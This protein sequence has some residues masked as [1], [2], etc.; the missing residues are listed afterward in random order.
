MKLSQLPF[1]PVFFD[2]YLQILPQELELSLGFQTLSAKQIFSLSDL[3]ALGEKVYAPGKW[4]AKETVQHC[5]DTERIL[6]YR[7]L[8]IARGEKQSLPGFDEN[9]YAQQASTAQR[10]LEELM[11]EFYCV[12][13][14]TSYLFSSFSEEILLRSGSANGTEITVAALGFAILGHGMHHKIIL[15]ERYL[16]LV[17]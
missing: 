11:A 17:R 1:V 3:Q 6:A 4:T 15:D 13:Q 9:A 14:S 5:I 10:S 12:Q 7:A 16:P 2:R 8:C